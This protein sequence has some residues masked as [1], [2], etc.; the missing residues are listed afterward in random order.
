MNFGSL[1][2]EYSKP[3]L[4]YTKSSLDVNHVMFIADFTGVDLAL[5]S[6]FHL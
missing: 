5:A 1:K 4:C 6:L 3:L 2:T